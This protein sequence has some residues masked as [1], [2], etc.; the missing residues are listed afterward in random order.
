MEFCP[1]C[2]FMLYTKLSHELED[3]E[4]SP[5]KL[6]N[7]CKNCGYQHEVEG[8]NKSV[9]KRNYEND[10]IADKI[11]SNKY[12]IYDSALPRLNLK[13][14]ND[15]CI[16]NNDDIDLNNTIYIKDVPEELEDSD[17]NMEFNVLFN[18]HMEMISDIKRVQ[19]T[20]AAIIIKQ[21]IDKEEMV[22]KILDKIT[23]P[24][25]DSKLK[26][27]N[28]DKEFNKPDREVLYIKYDPENM[29]YLYMCVN[30]GTSWLGNN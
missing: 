8:D 4:T 15:Q 20:M 10:F 25:K 30:C 21:G 7:Y 5:L 9:Y 19:L 13:C 11:L 17:F 29:K 23:S 28:I 22:S 2:N 26:G 6:F 27:L 14:V 3:D 1:K 16:T 18:D 12:T 24:S